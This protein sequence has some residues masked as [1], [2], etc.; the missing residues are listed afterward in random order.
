[1]SRSATEVCD[2]FTQID[3]SVVGYV[4]YIQV[5][6]TGGNFKRLHFLIADEYCDCSQLI[7]SLGGE[8]CSGSAYLAVLILNSIR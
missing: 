8:G 1:M 4:S 7:L 3:L 2:S 5:V 6:N